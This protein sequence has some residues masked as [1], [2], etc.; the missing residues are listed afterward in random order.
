MVVG[1]FMSV[2]VEKQDW[3]QSNI[4]RPARLLPR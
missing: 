4:F 1:V 2:S 3:N